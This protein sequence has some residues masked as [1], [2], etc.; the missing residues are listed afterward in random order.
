MYLLLP[1][2]LHLTKFGKRWVGVSVPNV[3]D[4]HSTREDTPGEKWWGSFGAFVVRNYLVVGS[5]SVAATIFVG[6]GLSMTRTSID[7]LELFDSRA[8]ILQDYRWLEKNLGRLVPLEIVVRF[9]HDSQVVG[10]RTAE[11]EQSDLYRLT[12]LERMETTKLIQDTIEREFGEGEGKPGIV[13]RSLSAANFLPSLPSTSGNTVSFIQRMAYNTRLN[14]S[15]DSLITSGFLRIDSRDDSELWRISLR[16]AAFAGVDYGQFV[17]EL[18]DKIEPLMLAHEQRVRVL[19]QLADWHPE[20][21]YAGA[22]VYLWEQPFEDRVLDQKNHETVNALESLLVTAR[23]KVHRGEPNPASIPVVTM[24]QLNELDGVV[25]AGNFSKAHAGTINWAIE[26]VIDLQSQ[27]T[28]KSTS[29][30]AIAPENEAWLSAVYTASYRLFTKL[31]ASCS[32]VSSRAP[33]GH[34]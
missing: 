22:E 8:R 24:Q 19:K 23:I 13:G 33:S 30:S 27:S 32:R 1:T 6:F 10:A 28:A 2:I 14:S 16:V 17:H 18:R 21:K 29:V 12:F 31:N 20:K 7:L 15:R 3:A 25:L 11:T 9:N 34:S 5:L 4:Q 26:R